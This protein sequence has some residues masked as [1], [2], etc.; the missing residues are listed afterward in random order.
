MKRYGSRYWL[1]HIKDAPA[2]G[3]AHDAELGKGIIDFRRLLASIDQIDNKVLY[4][5]Q[6]SYPG[7]P[8]ESAKRDF[9]YLSTLDF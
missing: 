4:V 6:E 5:E 8:L 7:T 9:A 3:A 2:L 1:F